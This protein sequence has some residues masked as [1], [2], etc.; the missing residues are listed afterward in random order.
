LSRHSEEIAYL[1]RLIGDFPAD[2]DKS[3][4]SKAFQRINTRYKVLENEFILKKSELF[5]AE[6]SEYID[7]TPSIM[8]QFAFSVHRFM[9]NSILSNAGEM[10]KSSDPNDGHIYFGGTKHQG[11]KQQFQGA[12]PSRI[13]TELDVA[14]AHLTSNADKPIRQAMRFYQHFVYIHPFYDGNGRIG[15]V[16]VSTYL[17]Q[18][19]YYVLWMAF[20]GPNNTQFINKL[21]ECHKRMKSGF[22]FDDY[23]GYLLNFFKKHV[24]SVDELN[25][26]KK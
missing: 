12:P 17:F 16:I 10:R 8:K 3:Q 21:N 14:F 15:R 24:V 9:F 11:H 23:F 13:N 6:E 18:F 20:D 25:D 4:A 1:K 19:N 5:N 7:A 22:R 2:F 26:L